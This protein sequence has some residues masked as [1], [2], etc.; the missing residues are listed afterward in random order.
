MTKP[1]SSSSV[2][3]TPDMH[4]GMVLLQSRYLPIS[5]NELRYLL[6]AWK[7]KKSEE[8]RGKH[9]SCANTAAANM[10]KNLLIYLGQ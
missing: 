5:R 8:A 1:E 4:G 9:N 6:Q 3:V 7:G 10:N 2:G